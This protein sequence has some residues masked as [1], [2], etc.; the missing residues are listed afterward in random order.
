M[1]F[2]MIAMDSNLLSNHSQGDRVDVAVAQRPGVVTEYGND[3]REAG[4][5][6]K[7]CRLRIV[8]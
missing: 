5:K 6:K 7:T 3:D 4:K 8:I 2:W 1:L